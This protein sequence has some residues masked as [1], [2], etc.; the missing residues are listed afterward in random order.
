MARSGRLAAIAVVVVVVAL[1]AIWA[2]RRLNGDEGRL[3]VAGTV[4]ALQVDVS[5]KT[6]GRIV[7]L[8]VREGQP[9]ERGQ[10]LV[11]LDREELAAE[12]RRAA[13]AVRSAQAQLRDLEAGA[14]R[15]EIEEA[16]ARAVQAQARLDDLLAGARPQEIEQ[17][18]ANL[19]NAEATRVWAERDFQRARELF[20][21]EL[22]AAAEVDRARQTYDVAVAN[23][24][25]A[26]ERLRLV[27]AGP[28][29]DEV[30]A[31]RAEVRAA[32]ERAQLL[33]A[34]PRANAV[35]AARSQVTEAQ[36]AAALAQARLAETLLYSPLTG[37]VLRKNLE[38]GETANP[39]VPIL[40]L[41]DP[42]DVWLRAYVA[43]TDIGQLRIGQ[44]ADIMVDAYPGRRF[45]GEVTEI[46]SKAEFTPKNVQTKKGRVNLVFRV[47]IAVE[48]PEGV[49][50]PGM[51]ADAEFR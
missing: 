24:T 39:G 51:P 38:V 6:P 32:R 48:N 15:E 26:R 5:A 23:E 37:V 34:G 31:A 10:L 45:A 35:E 13:A 21:K 42:R 30:A 19:R 43:E 47:K 12:A 18:R 36:A 29:E 25:T 41:M 22:I 9:V 46:A 14:R 16:E 17:A 28:R 50:K 49:L 33:R 3:G 1:A 44:G 4:E 11:R 27:E 8:T 2:T 40:T 20:G 7:E